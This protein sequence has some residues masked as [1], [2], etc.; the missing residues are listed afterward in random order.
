MQQDYFHIAT[1]AGARSLRRALGV[2]DPSFTERIAEDVRAILYP[3]R[4]Q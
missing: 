2:V 3:T 4:G 1:F